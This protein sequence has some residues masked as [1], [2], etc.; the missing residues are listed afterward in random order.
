M[1]EVAEQGRRDGVQRT[2]HAD[3]LGDHLRRLL[4]GRALPDAERPRRPAGHR[5]R[6]RDRGV[7]HDLPVAQVVLQVG[8]R[9][10]LAAERDAQDHDLRP[11]GGRAVGLAGEAA[12]GDAL[13][14]ALDRLLGPR[15]VARADDD[16]HAGRSEPQREPE[17][18]RAGAT[19]DRHGGVHEAADDI[20]S[21]VAAT[22]VRVSVARHDVPLA[23]L[24]TLRL[25]G[26][27]R[28]LVEAATEADVVEAVR[29][30]DAAGEPLLVLAGGSNVVIAD[31]GFDGT[32]VRIL[33]RGVE[34]TGERLEVQA[35]E[36]WDALVAACV[37][38]GL[39]G[40]ECLSGIPGS[41]GATPIQNVGAYGQDVSET[42]TAVR[43]Y[44]RATR[45]V[46]TLDADACRF[47]YRSSVFK[48]DDRR[49]VL[50]V[51]FRLRRSAVSGPLR[52][53]ELARALER[54]F[55]GGRAAG[56]GP[57]GRARPAPRQGH[58]HRPRRPR[59]GERGLLLH[60]PD[61]R[62]RGLRSAP[63][64]A[65]GPERRPPAWPEPD[66]RV[67]TSAAWLIEQAGFRRGHGDGRAGISAKHTLALVNRGEASTEELL[68]VAREV[69][70]GVR[71][72][73]GV[74]LMPEPVLVGEAW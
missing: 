21:H 8:Q 59:L 41:T 2:D 36:D 33:T 67:K 25:G 52:Y 9:L 70:A 20:P 3:A 51:A 72:A 46:T 48:R 56:G 26:P 47:R 60:Q 28:R 4:G 40:F 19:D 22:V 45:E 65:A 7:D 53:G 42:V 71:E 37:G 39:A 66:G 12:L 24:T 69:A 38:D 14:E 10:G 44:D 18:E 27:A 68:A 30:A 17:A 6:Q 64:P 50:S 34:R 49:V 55:G 63:G 31:E 62:P 16:R 61:P 13:A 32:V 29:E 74:E 23:P 11:R 35:G 15:R 1:V 58:G 57:G 5:G 43:V 54:R 73:F